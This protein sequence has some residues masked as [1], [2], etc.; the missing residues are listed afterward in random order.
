MTQYRLYFFSSAGGHIREVREFEAAHDF[1]AVS[2]STQWRSTDAMELWSGAR[3]VTR[4]VAADLSSFQDGS[5]EAPPFTGN[6]MNRLGEQR[7]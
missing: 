6:N 4:W 7:S 5:N 1:A 3:K 2:Q